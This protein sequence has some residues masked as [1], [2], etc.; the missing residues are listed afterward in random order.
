M[1][2]IAIEPVGVPRRIQFIGAALGAGLALIA[3][4]V[5]YVASAN[6]TVES[7]IQMRETFDSPGGHA[8]AVFV[9]VAGPAAA[10]TAGWLFGPAASKRTRWVGVTMGVA[11][12]LLALLL[13]VGAVNLAS[14][15]TS[16]DSILDRISSVF[17]AAPL[18]A[19]FVALFLAP[20][21]I[22]C[23]VAGASWEFL[24]RRAVAGPTTDAPRAFLYGEVAKL[25]A[26]YGILICFASLAMYL[27]LSSIAWLSGS[28]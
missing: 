16:N 24:V 23:L 18:E 19:A 11:T 28:D 4:G 10:A 15:L 3:L 21:F 12:Y 5:L 13:L 8:F 27:F 26:I 7:L 14:A 25:I 17:L 9:W 6:A 1:S 2:T 20:V 22:A